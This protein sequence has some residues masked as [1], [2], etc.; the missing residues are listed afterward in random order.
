MRISETV[1]T[2]VLC[3]GTTMVNAQDYREE[4]ISGV[5]DPCL[6]EVLLKDSGPPP[7]ISEIEFLEVTKLALPVS[8]IDSIIDAVQGVVEGRNRKFREAWYKIML[9]KCVVD[10]GKGLE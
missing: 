6:L 10:V 9:N 2:V 1:L 5:V 4:I 7:G 3:A 8:T